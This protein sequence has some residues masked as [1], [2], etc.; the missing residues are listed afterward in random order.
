MIQVMAAMRIQASIR[1]FL[2]KKTLHRNARMAKM[3]QEND[4]VED[5]VV[6][7]ASKTKPQTHQK[8]ERRL[9]SFPK[10][11]SESPEKNQD[12]PP[13]VIDAIAYTS[14]S[15]QEV[16]HV[17]TIPKIITT[18][19]YVA[20]SNKIHVRSLSKYEK[21]TAKAIKVLRKS[22]LFSEVMEAVS[23]LEKTTSKSIDSCKLL[24][25]ASG[26]DNLLSLLAS[27]NRSSP[28]LELVRVV[29]HIFKNITGHQASLSVL[30]TRE[31]MS[32]MTD[33]VQMFR[34]KADIFELSTLLLETFVRS[35]AFI[36][37][38]HSS[39]EQRRCLREVLS[40]SRK[41]ASVFDRGILCLDNVMNIVEGGTII[42]S[43]PKCPYCDREFT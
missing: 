40:L 8:Q 10:M 1:C 43:K 41:R 15:K 33:V 37:S 11:L 27:C 20:T 30:V 9:E 31:V 36:L 25:K 5:S 21:H 23:I 39:H 42:E 28:H 22:D 13:R 6:K 38:E 26:Q 19:S 4:L 14:D 18:A 17:S 35:D 7:E 2:K 32:K 16:K 29:L 24:L 12:S 34:D 3:L